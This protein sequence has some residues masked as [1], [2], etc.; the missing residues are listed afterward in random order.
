MITRVSELPWGP[1]LHKIRC[2][3]AC[4]G[5]GETPTRVKVFPG[6][7][8][9]NYRD[10]SARSGLQE[11][12]FFGF[13]HSCLLNKEGLRLDAE[14][15]LLP[16]RGLDMSEAPPCPGNNTP[17]PG[18]SLK[19]LYWACV[20]ND[21][22]E[23]QARLDVGVSPE[24]A[25]QVDSNGRVSHPRAHQS[26]RGQCFTHSILVWFPRESQSCP[27]LF[28]WVKTVFTAVGTG[29]REVQI[30]GGRRES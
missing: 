11:E 19:T 5:R 28:R 17:S 6:E 12:L 26:S 25:S 13:C 3:V 30:G 15:P 7:T 20:H 2:L 16:R 23:L 14:E 27:P 22:A 8:S 4:H 1:N 10:T 24:E 29:P 21:L 9:Y 18:C